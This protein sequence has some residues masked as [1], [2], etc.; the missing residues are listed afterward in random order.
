LSES[1]FQQSLKNLTNIVANLRSNKSLKTKLEHPQKGEKD[2]LQENDGKE[3]IS[4]DESLLSEIEYEDKA[5]IQNESG[6]IDSDLGI[7]LNESK[8]ILL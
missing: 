1:E 7:F 3:T 4:F 2:T 5:H 8:G 6:L